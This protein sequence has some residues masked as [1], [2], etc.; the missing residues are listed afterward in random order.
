MIGGPDAR[1]G[2]SITVDNHRR[3]TFAN[4]IRIQINTPNRS[5]RK[6]NNTRHDA[7]SATQRLTDPRDDSLFPQPAR[8][9][10]GRRNQPNTTPHTNQP[11][12]NR[13]LR[14]P[15][16]EERNAIRPTGLNE[17]RW[18]DSGAIES[19]AGA[20]S[21]AIAVSMATSIDGSLAPKP[22]IFEELDTGYIKRET[23]KIDVEKVEAGIGPDG[24]IGK[25]EVKASITAEEKS[26]EE[27]VDESKVEKG[28][29]E[30]EKV[31]GAAAEPKAQAP[32]EERRISQPQVSLVEYEDFQRQRT[33]FE[34]ERHGLYTRCS[35]AEGTLVEQRQQW[36]HLQ[37]ENKNLEGRL[38]A[39]IA[40]D[41]MN[42]DQLVEDVKTI[43]NLEL[44]IAAV[45]K[46]SEN[47]TN[48]LSDYQGMQ[49]QQDGLNHQLMIG[50]ADF[51][52]TFRMFENQIAGLGQEVS[53]A[54]ACH[55]GCDGRIKALE[56]DLERARERLTSL[57]LAHDVA[58]DKLTQALHWE[59]AQYSELKD[60]QDR[61]DVATSRA[62]GFETQVGDLKAACGK[63]EAT[64]QELKALLEE[65]DRLLEEKDGKLA[66]LLSQRLAKERKKSRQARNRRFD[67]EKE[68][69]NH[70]LT[71]QT[72]VVFGPRR[73]PAQHVSKKF[74]A[75]IIKA[76]L[77][78][79]GADNLIFHDINRIS[80]F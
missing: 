54:N 26:V 75:G 80:E 14:S 56:G 66:E 31:E 13:E 76:C 72:L 53:Q 74:R 38:A 15:Q 17:S 37:S 43:Q 25:D 48:R 41:Q 50:R 16:V 1:L 71:S 29:L 52:A 55:A 58:K 61:L 69:E 51:Q 44:G 24:K 11:Y 42:Q 33:K 36:Q 18:A 70:K 2:D 64:E 32:H 30:G 20:A 27:N 21:T 49:R 28:I 8:L 19:H 67:A 6:Q 60:K 7:T 45:K 23:S 68:Q 78:Q 57:Q 59:E 79:M 34:A 9:Q 4:Q 22:V 77:A 65:K 63:H 35:T 40:V 3:T 39:V 12:N 5:Q 46:E 62:A 10:A 47:V 73:C